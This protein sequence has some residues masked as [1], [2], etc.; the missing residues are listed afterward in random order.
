MSIERIKQ[1]KEFPKKV[2]YQ[3]YPKS[4]YDTTGSGMGDLQG[5]IAKLDY[6]SLIHI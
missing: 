6:L 5:V 1:M 4:F 3:I 2:V